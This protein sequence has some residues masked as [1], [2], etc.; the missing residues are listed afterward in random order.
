MCRGASL[1]VLY[2]APA[3]GGARG[4][5]GRSDT[6]GGREGGGVNGVAGLAGSPV[7]PGRDLGRRRH[8]LLPVLRARRGRR[9]LPVRRAGQRDPGAVAER[10][11]F[12]WHCYLPGVGPGPAL[13]LPGARPVGPARGPPVRPGQAPHRPLRQGHRGGRCGGS[14]RGCCLDGPDGRPDA[15]PAQRDSAP[16]IPKCVVVDPGFDW[17]DDRHPET[18][19][20]R[21]V[22][23][24]MHVKGFT[25]R[26]P[27]VREDLRGTY[28]GLAIRRGDRPPDVARRDRGRAA[29][30][31]PLP[32]RAPP[33]RRGLTQLLGLQL[34][35]LLRARRRAT[36]PAAAAA[37]RCASSRSMV[38]ALHRAGIE[39]ILDVV[40]N[41]TAEGNHVGPTLSFKGIDNTVYYR[42]D[43]GRP[44]RYYLDFTGT[45]NS[46]NAVH[47]QRAAAD[48]GQPALLG[49][50]MHVDGFRFDLASALARELY[51]VD[52]LGAFFD[53][54]HQDPVL[55]PGQ[56]HRRAVGRRRRRLPGGQLPR[57]LE[58]VERPLPRHRA[59][60]WR[61]DGARRGR[62]RRPGSP[63]QPTSTERRPAPV[64]HAST[65][66]PRTTA[67]PSPTSSPTSRS[68]TRRT[69]RTTATAPT[70]T[71]AGTAASR[72]RPTTRAIRALRERQQRNFLATLLLSQGVPMLVGGDEIGRTQRGNNNAYCQDNELSWFDWE[73]DDERRELSPSRAG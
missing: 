48:H 6:W 58:R 34:D 60:F 27:S 64:R 14:R 24:E 23:Y 26:T 57:A 20:H 37:S 67:S 21:S 41:H 29:A 73:L 61:G 18:P 71:A 45:G 36:R 22:I 53:T 33:R 4:R 49:A 42:L 38:K 72:G 44:S 51:D 56:A 8:Q 65:S 50:E 46:L 11:A 16:A 52:R 15:D 68:T 31:A 55:S 10:T 5:A 47:P 12:N 9:A 69:A 1:P 28:A 2:H 19:L 59:R 35:R 3:R 39:V 30:G 7:P 43:A 62:A 66:S 13:R 54:I 63:A 25:M 40:Y 32:R 70:T 17:E